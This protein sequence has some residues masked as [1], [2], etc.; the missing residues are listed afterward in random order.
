MW[1][2]NVRSYITPTLALG[3]ELLWFLAEELLDI[4]IFRNFR[5]E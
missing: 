1:M 2:G 4:R 3:L 5:L